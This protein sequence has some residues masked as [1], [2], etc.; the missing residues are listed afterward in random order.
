MILLSILY[1]TSRY[2]WSNDRTIGGVPTTKCLIGAFGILYRPSKYESLF[3]CLLFF[4]VTFSLHLW[5]ILYVETISNYVKLALICFEN[6]S[7]CV[8]LALSYFENIS[9]CVKLALSCFENI[10]NCVK[11]ALSGLEIILNCLKLVPKPLWLSVWNFMT[12]PQI[13]YRVRA[14]KKKCRV[15]KFSAVGRLSQTVDLF[16]FRVR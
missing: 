14:W 11:L 13:L 5:I 2:I 4:M 9:N 15:F 12:F 10:S 1:R 16:L 7:N 6:I 8:K 3:F